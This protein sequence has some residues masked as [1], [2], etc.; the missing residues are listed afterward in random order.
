MDHSVVLPSVDRLSEDRR[1]VA[2]ATV[3]DMEVL[4]TLAE[5]TP[6]EDSPQVD[7]LRSVDLR[8]SAVADSAARLL[9]LSTVLRRMDLRDRDTH[10]SPRDLHSVAPHS[11]DR[12]VEDLRLSD[13]PAAEVTRS[14][15]AATHSVEALP[16]PAMAH[17]QFPRRFPRSTPRTVDTPKLTC[18]I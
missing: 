6:A 4:D 12:S 16:P 8:R 2:A 14:V 15:E 18:C 11:E 10:L 17:P 3:M 13:R 9:L 5:D 7:L 1:S